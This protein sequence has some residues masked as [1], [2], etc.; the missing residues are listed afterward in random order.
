MAVPLRGRTPGSIES[1]AL[2]TTGYWYVRLCRTVLGADQRKS[3]PLA[4]L[5]P[6][7]R[8]R[9]LKSLLELPDEIGLISL[10]DLGPTVAQMRKFHQLNILSIEVLAAAYHLQ[11]HVFLSATSPLLE[12]ALLHENLTVKVARPK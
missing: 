1:K 4:E 6:S 11:A 10:R 5:S 7:L 3:R 2:H 9:A 12:R 8:E